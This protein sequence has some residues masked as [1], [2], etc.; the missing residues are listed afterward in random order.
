MKYAEPGTVIHGTLRH[1]DLIK[2]FTDTLEACL[3]QNPDLPSNGDSY[4]NLISDARDAVPDTEL[5]SELITELMDAL[6]EFAPANHYF[7]AHPEDGSDFGFWENE[8]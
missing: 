7:G 2:A 6:N 3:A 4:L 1:E 8:D 5:S